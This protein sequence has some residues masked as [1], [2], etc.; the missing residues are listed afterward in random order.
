MCDIREPSQL[1]LRIKTRTLG[2]VTLAIAAW[3]GTFYVL[4]M[5]NTPSP[6]SPGLSIGDL[7]G[8]DS[9]G[10]AEA[11]E[12]FPFEFPRDHGPHNRFRSEWWYF[13]GN[14]DDDIGR[15]YGFQ[16]TFFRFGLSR[17]VLERDSAWSTSNIYMGHFALTDVSE[18]KLISFERLSREA[19]GLAGA[20][21]TPFQ[22]WIDHWRIQ[23]SPDSLF[24]MALHASEDE[25]SLTLEVESDKPMV[26]QGEQGLSQ[27]SDEPGNASYYYSFTRLTVN[28]RLKIRKGED[29][30]VTGT[31]WMDREWSTS[32]LSANQ[33]GWDW[34]SIQLDDD[35]E[36]MFYRFRRHDGALDRH[37]AGV[38]VDAQH[39]TRRLEASDVELEVV[40]QWTNRQGIQYP[41]RWRIR[42]PQEHLELEVDAY[43]FNQ[44]I[45]HSVRYW[46]GAVSV[47]GVRAGRTIAGDGYLEMTGYEDSCLEQNC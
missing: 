28:G 38:F 19:L 20:T 18:R 12:P 27:K 35:T 7:L 33:V 11:L 3:I 9:S 8:G 29:K 16:L 1:S 17:P 34:F 14:L 24:P 15:H 31:A 47:H 23:S 13:T 40:E 39:R 26:I 44:E 36:L 46:E 6:A 5:D 45:N 21:A 30:A 22:V 42:V 43:V 41:V 2:V 32:A 4:E 25:V 10:F 37:S